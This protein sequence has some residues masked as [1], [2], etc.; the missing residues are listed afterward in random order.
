MPDTRESGLRRLMNGIRK[1]SLF[2]AI[3]LGLAFL[4]SVV[5]VLTGGL[6]GEGYDI[7]QGTISQ[8]LIQSPVETVNEWATQALREEA[9]RDARA[10]PIYKQDNG[11]TQAAMDKLDAF[12]RDI[13]EM[14]RQHNP[15]I[16]PTSDSR[17]GPVPVENLNRAALSLDVSTFSQFNF[18]IT[19][20]SAVFNMFRDTV[21]G[22]TE[23][24][25]A[26]GIKEDALYSVSLAVKDELAMI[27][28][29][30]TAVKN[31]GY[32]IITQI[33]KTNI[34]IDEA[35]MEKAARDAMD[36]VPPVIIHRGQN[37]VREGELITPEIFAV[38]ESLNLVRSAV[39]NKLPE[40]AGSVLAIA[41]MFAALIL[42]FATAYGRKLEERKNVVLLFSLYCAA[43]ILARFLEG[44]NFVFMPIILFTMLTAI[45]LDEGLAAGFSVGL[46]VITSVVCSGDIMFVLFFI[47]C[48]LFSAFMARLI[49]ERN[50]MLSVTAIIS[51]F[52][53]VTVCAVFL[54]VNGGVSKYMWDTAVIAAL[55]G[56]FSV[57]LCV[58]VLPFLETAFGFITTIKLVDLA[59][60]NNPLLRRLTIEAPGTYHH[61]LMV[62]NLAETACYAIGANHTL[63][64]IG[65][66]YHDAGK[67]NYPQ[68]F[69]ENVTDGV[70]PHDSLEPRMSAKIIIE[71]VAAGLELAAQHKLPKPVRKFIEEHHG[72]SIQTY[73]LHKAK[74]AAETDDDVNEAD[75]KYNYS[76]PTSRE[77]A[78]VML[79]DIVEAAVRSVMPSC[80][81]EGKL[82]AFIGGLVKTALDENRLRQSRLNIGELDDIVAAF[83]RVFRGMHHERIAY[84]T[85][86][87]AASTPAKAVKTVKPSKP[88]AKAKTPD[89]PKA[90]PTG[91]TAPVPK[92]SAETAAPVKPVTE[93]AAAP[94]AGK[95]E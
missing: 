49:T 85:A 48:G 5:C 72:Q 82:S 56:V 33:L 50:K 3:F 30:D 69:I 95:D 47:I 75:Y 15:V 6:T 23:A 68:Y 77:S 36:A 54:V 73:F 53:G 7:E 13:E 40:I 28:E 62:S 83:V 9:A 39:Y 92:V 16:D 8:R 18:M 17:Q 46:S 27:D 55:Y 45:L 14:R 70:N 24:R 29:W 34:F 63:A 88:A 21:R 81:E 1:R 84:P 86:G 43:V 78:V 71:H 41:A 22:I 64:R 87:D 65:G 42:F 44:M 80:T 67:L 4:T 2:N 20:D 57:V 37:I 11:V 89:I 32:N 35:S 31:T 10:N 60:P 90:A 61:S 26:S 58:G 74:K 38:L 51:G 25:M 93:E 76:A 91:K 59:N 19:C 12:F 66:Y 52:C 79:A 94:A